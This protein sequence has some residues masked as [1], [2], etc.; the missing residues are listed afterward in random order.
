MVD[1]FGKSALY[2]GLGV[3]ILFIL[4]KLDP[5]FSLGD[6]VVCFGGRV[7]LTYTLITERN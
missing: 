3:N 4:Q 7:T 1:L 5:V 6:L 2:A